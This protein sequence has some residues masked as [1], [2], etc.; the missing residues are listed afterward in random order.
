[1]DLYEIR[2][3]GTLWHETYDVKNNSD[4]KALGIMRFS[5]CGPRGGSGA[6]KCPNC[7]HEIET[8]QMRWQHQMRARGQCIACAKPVEKIAGKEYAKCLSCR[9]K[10]AFRRRQHKDAAGERLHTQVHRA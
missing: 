7:L 2:E 5:G 6:V 4:P 9:R 1:M 3:D 8:P 10:D